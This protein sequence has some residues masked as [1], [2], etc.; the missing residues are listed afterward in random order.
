MRMKAPRLAG[1][2]DYLLQVTRYSTNGTCRTPTSSTL[3][4]GWRRRARHYPNSVTVA[5]Y[6][7]PV[8]GGGFAFSPFCRQ[9]VLRSERW[10]AK[11][12]GVDTRQGPQRLMAPYIVGPKP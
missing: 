5:N 2:L 12:A 8:G 6:H 10:I 7:L 11:D 3:E 4:R 9:E 1:S